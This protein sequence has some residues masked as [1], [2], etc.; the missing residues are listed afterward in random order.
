MTK[1]AVEIKVE[2]TDTKFL[3]TD[4]PGELPKKFGIITAFTDKPSKK[5]ALSNWQADRSL[6][7]ALKDAKYA[8]FRVVLI[9]KDGSVSEPGYAFEA[10]ESRHVAEIA[11][12]FAQ[13]SF[14]WIVNDR[15]Q[16]KDARCLV[17][18]DLGSFN[19]RL[20]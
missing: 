8:P 20:I 16:I 3:L 13:R 18:D 7:C 12:R 2:E 5:A 6:F 19:A 10:T 11:R 9:S 4:H 1:E 14:F 15:L 17:F